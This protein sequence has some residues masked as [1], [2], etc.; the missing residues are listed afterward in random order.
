MKAKTL[1]VLAGVSAPLILTGSVSAG[2]VGI[3]VVGKETG[4]IPGVGELFV[5]NVYAVFDRPDDE[6][7]TVFGT[8]ANPLNIF[9]KQGKWYQDP[10]G[11]W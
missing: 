3:K 6:M 7:I 9:V 1:F 8:A 10:E 5:C 2:F 11:R 4:F